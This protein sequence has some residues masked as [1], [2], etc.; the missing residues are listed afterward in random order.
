MKKQKKNSYWLK[1]IQEQEEKALARTEKET[2]KE[3]AR[4]YRQTITQ[5][6]NDILKV[7]SKV[8][9]DREAGRELLI[10][11]FYR[12]NRYWELF[13]TINRRL[14]ALGEKQIKITEPKI[15]EMYHETQVILDE[16]IPED[17][18]K[19]QFL[20][21]KAVD[22]KQALFQSWCLDGKNFSDRVWED[23]AKMLE[24]LKR[25]LNTCIIQGKSP[26]EAAVRV[27]DQLGVSERSAYRLMRTE[28]AHA[29]NYAATEKYKQL[30]F[31]KGKWNASNCACSHCKEQDGTIHPLTELANQIPAHP[32][33]RCTYSV[34]V[35]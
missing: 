28:L 13:D 31:T 35:D 1:R 6:W 34:V 16:G 15:L 19:T 21:T 26:W 10:N 25:E 23:K 33:C 12:N 4:I 11:D 8:E 5:V 29:Q 3:L 2:E 30:G 32:N 17:K 20:N 9:A 22:A 27:S 24:V 7:Y 18:V 14:V